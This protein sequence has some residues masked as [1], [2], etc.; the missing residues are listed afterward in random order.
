MHKHRGRNPHGQREIP[1]LSQ[2]R[3]RHGDLRK[4]RVHHVTLHSLEKAHDEAKIQGQ[5]RLFR[6]RFP[7]AERLRHLGLRIYPS[8]SQGQ[9][10]RFPPHDPDRYDSAFTKAQRDEWFSQIWALKGTRQTSSELERRTGAFPEEI[11]ERLIRMFSVKGDMV[12]DPFLGSGTT[13]KAALHSERS[14]VGF[15][16]DQNLLQIITR[17]IGDENAGA[18]FEIIKR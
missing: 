17:K 9:P 13:A 18:D 3:P 16:V 5:R 10:A 7:T 2:P 6:L 1:A 8:L 15:E 4:N 14:S 11:A 12:L